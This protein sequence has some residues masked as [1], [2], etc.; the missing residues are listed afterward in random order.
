MYVV[1]LCLRWDAEVKLGVA[2]GVCV[3]RSF[4]GGGVAWM[5]AVLAAEVVLLK[6]ASVEWR[7]EERVVE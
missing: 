5:V 4:C 2:P 7:R 6:T 3:W 1:V